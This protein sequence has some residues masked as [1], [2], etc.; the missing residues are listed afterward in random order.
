METKFSN[1]LFITFSLYLLG[2]EFNRK[3][4]KEKWKDKAEGEGTAIH[5]HKFL[6]IL[7]FEMRYL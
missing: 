2:K 7:K 4:T 1:F 3:D 6:A 5:I